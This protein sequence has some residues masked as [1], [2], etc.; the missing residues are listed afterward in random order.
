MHDELTKDFGI[1][2]VLLR[3]YYKTVILNQLSALPPALKEREILL[4]IN[5]NLTRSKTIAM[6]IL[7]FRPTFRKNGHYI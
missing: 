1:P 5:I 6:T 7:S 4:Y 3:E 2:G